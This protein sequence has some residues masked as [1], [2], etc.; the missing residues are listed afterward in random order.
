[1]A[2]TPSPD[3]AGVFFFL[4]AC[5]AGCSAL[6]G[7]VGSARQCH[8]GSSYG[9]MLQCMTMKIVVTMIVSACLIQD[10]VLGRRARYRLFEFHAHMTS[11]P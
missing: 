7:R 6:L 1:M 3:P 2:E 9:L 5:W 11:L 4:D 8:P 10:Q